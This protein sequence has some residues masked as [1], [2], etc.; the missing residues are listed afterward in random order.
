MSAPNVSEITTKFRVAVGTAPLHPYVMLSRGIVLN[1]RPGIVAKIAKGK[2]IVRIDFDDG[3]HQEF[4]VASLHHQYE[5]VGVPGRPTGWG[6]H[7][8]IF[9]CQEKNLC[10]A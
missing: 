3:E 8:I 6:E 7:D 4:P 9:P 1:K 5:M 10:D 2:G